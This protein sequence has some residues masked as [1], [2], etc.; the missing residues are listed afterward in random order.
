MKF[1]EL[2]SCLLLHWEKNHKHFTVNFFSVFCRHGLTFKA[3]R[4]D[5]V[6]SV[7]IM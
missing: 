3:E 4:F 7:Y 6:D 2:F 1:I 5:A